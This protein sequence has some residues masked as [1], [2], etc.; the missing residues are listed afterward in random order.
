MILVTQLTKIASGQI[1]TTIPTISTRNHFNLSSGELNSIQTP[2]SYI[3]SANIPG[4]KVGKTCP[5]E[6]A[7]YIHGVWVG[8]NSLEKPEEIFD[9]AKKSIT[10]NNFIIPL[11][12][13]SGILIQRFYLQMVPDGQQLKL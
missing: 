7:I 12:G 3:A 10:A 6:V 11:V 4:F 1:T 8:S 9:R 13:F 5:P 2:T